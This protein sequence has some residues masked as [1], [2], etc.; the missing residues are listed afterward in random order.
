ELCAEC[1][2]RIGQRCALKC[3]E[4]SSLRHRERVAESSKRRID[5]NRQY[6]RCENIEEGRTSR[7]WE[8][9]QA[10]SRVPYWLTDILTPEFFSHPLDVCETTPK[11]LPVGQLTAADRS[12]LPNIRSRPCHDSL[13]NLPEDERPRL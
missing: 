5:Q 3:V 6:G 11:K 7:G 12:H 8:K 13:Q 4:G 1:G 9:I 10:S 2:V